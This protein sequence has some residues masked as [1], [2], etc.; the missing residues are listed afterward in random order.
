MVLDK[1]FVELI[2]KLKYKRFTT[3]DN[4]SCCLKC[5]I[6]VSSSDNPGIY[7]Y[8]NIGAWGTMAEALNGLS[9]F[10]VLKIF[11]HIEEQVYEGQCK[12]CKGYEKKYYTEVIVDNF[13][14]IE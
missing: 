14:I 5:K 1:N 11:G 9:N 12:H 10:C 8:I 2:G 7:Q 13:K 3:L 4:G 6:A